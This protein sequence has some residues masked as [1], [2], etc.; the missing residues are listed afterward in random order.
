MK[1]EVLCVDYFVT[2]VEDRPGKGADL[3]RML[4]KEKVNLLATMAFPLSPGKVQ[5]DIVPENP[6]VFTA[7]AKKLGL[8]VRGP[9]LA[10]MIH[11]TNKPGAM[12]EILD[13]LAKKNIGIR[14]TCSV[15]T[16][17]NQY[18]AILWVAPADVDA[19]TQ[20]LGARIAAHHHV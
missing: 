8:Q 15:T 10:F 17:G 11:G 13:R 1:D 6:D 12:G 14:S 2:E 16:G 7:A 20:A 19:A 3:E 5:V 4:T 18:G 9:K